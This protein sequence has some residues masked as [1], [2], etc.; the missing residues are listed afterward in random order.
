MTVPGISE[1]LPNWNRSM[2]T[3]KE[4]FSELP[5]EVNAYHIGLQVEGHV[6]AA[7]AYLIYAQRRVKQ[8]LYERPFEDIPIP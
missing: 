6:R 3:R 7:R 4:T 5:L 1:N 8:F 2:L